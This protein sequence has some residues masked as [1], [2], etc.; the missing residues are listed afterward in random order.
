MALR[1]GTARERS[2]K[3][4]VVDGT[5]FDDNE[6]RRTY[7]RPFHGHTA[8]IALKLGSGWV[9]GR[10]LARVG[11]GAIR[12]ELWQ[13]AFRRARRYRLESYGTEYVWT[14]A[15]VRGV[16]RWLTDALDGAA[17]SRCS[18]DGDPTP[19]GPDLSVLLA[20]TSAPVN[21]PALIAEHPNRLV[22]DGQWLASRGGP[23]WSA[24]SSAY[25][26]IV[27]A[28]CT[29]AIDVA[30]M[31]TADGRITVCPLRLF[32]FDAGLTESC[33][34]VGEVNDLLAPGITRAYG[35][36]RWGL[37]GRPV[38]WDL[39]SVDVRARPGFWTQW[40]YEPGRRGE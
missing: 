17:M 35:F 29:A 3:V 21:W 6:F 33:A 26:R 15:P 8:Q 39:D 10:Q 30:L 18:A 36:E 14:V 32:A 9:R 24:I 31:A 38:Q 7:T 4:P 27:S 22:V 5:A 25:E 40:I 1:V 11:I 20:R 2:V 28:G 13:S 16:P 12:A 19:A 23:Q 34:L 37:S